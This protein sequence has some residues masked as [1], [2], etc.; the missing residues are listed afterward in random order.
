MGEGG[1]TKACWN[2]AEGIQDLAL[3][4]RFCGADQINKTL[5]KQTNSSR[6][7]G[8]VGC[9]GTGIA[10]VL[11]LIFFGSMMPDSPE[12]KA[13]EVARSSPPVNDPAKCQKIIDLASRQGLVRER[14]SRERINVDERIWAA[15]PASEKS[16]VMQMLLCSAFG[17]RD[18]T[19]VE[20]LDGV[21]AYGYHSGKRLAMFGSFG[22]KFE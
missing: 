8:G 6:A 18:M 13:A 21:V 12:K 2:C 17:G 11:V 22:L 9:L 19:Q 3:R 20:P 10:I 1:M 14:P 7:S 5:P 15:T 16:V 4:C